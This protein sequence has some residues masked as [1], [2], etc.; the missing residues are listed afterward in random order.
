MEPL[1]GLDPKNKANLR[2][3][4]S[5]AG[6][7]LVR[8]I[9]FERTG[10]AS[11]L[12]TILNIYE[13]GLEYEGLLRYGEQEGIAVGK[14]SNSFSLPIGNNV[15]LE[16]FLGQFKGFYTLDNK[17]VADVSIKSMVNP[18]GVAASPMLGTEH[19]VPAKSNLPAPNVQAQQI[20]NQLGIS[21]IG[22]GLSFEKGKGKGKTS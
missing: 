15:A 9:R 11:P 1:F 12:Y 7:K 13:N 18:G 8:T 3:K 17:C 20:L 2:R 16:Y 22:K 5:L 6:K 19:H 14:Y 10:Q 4:A 21:S